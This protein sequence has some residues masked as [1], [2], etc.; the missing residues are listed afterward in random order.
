MRLLDRFNYHGQEVTSKT[1][2]RVAVLASCQA[3]LWINMVFF[4]MATN[5]RATLRPMSAS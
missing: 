5:S 1:Q 2:Q 4:D 3:V